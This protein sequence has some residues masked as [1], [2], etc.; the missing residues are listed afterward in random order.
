MDWAQSI[1][2]SSQQSLKFEIS[3]SVIDAVSHMTSG[4]GL[5][6][7]IANPLLFSRFL[8]GFS[9]ELQAVE[10]PLMQ[11]M[12]VGNTGENTKFVVVDT[13]PDG[14]LMRAAILRMPRKQTFCTALSQCVE[15]GFLNGFFSN[16][17]HY[18]PQDAK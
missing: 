10:L 17:G 8:A 11:D 12:N 4:A 15:N 9:F 3:Q 7:C 13:L 1:N 14:H 2:S 5:R 18:R 16:S 6:H